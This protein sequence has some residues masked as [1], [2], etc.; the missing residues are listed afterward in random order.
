MFARLCLLSTLIVL[1]TILISIPA[2]GQDS[3]QNSDSNLIPTQLPGALE[4]ARMQFE[5]ARR[6]YRTGRF[7]L[8][9]R[10]FE[11]S[12]E[13]SGHRELLYNAHMAYR[14]AGMFRDALRTLE[15]YVPSIEDPTTLAANQARLE[16]LREVV[17]RLD[18][19]PEPHVEPRVDPVDAEEETVD[20]EDPNPIQEHTRVPS[21]AA[22]R[23]GWSSAGI[24]GA[25][26]ITSTA[27]GVAALRAEQDLDDA[28]CS[29]AICPQDASST[30]SRGRRLQRG[31]D[32]LWVSA[33]VVAAVG[34]IW[35]LVRK[36]RQR[37]SAEVRF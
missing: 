29:S 20:A 34:T 31:T 30:L 28:G 12:Y 3:P 32:A 7:E 4:E 16:R 14:Q 33:L 1:L 15:G 5:L 9:G 27:T 26:A 10:T 13:L 23:I 22:R 11:T 36:G 2:Y 19:E 35:A 8:A 6:Y 21:R 17:A 18:P 25:L 24:A 37:L